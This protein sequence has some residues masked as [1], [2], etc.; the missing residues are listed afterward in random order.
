MI[1]IIPSLPINNYLRDINYISFIFDFNINLE[2]CGVQVNRSYIMN[3]F[4]NL[5]VYAGK[6]SVK[7]TRSFTDEEKSAIVQAVVVPSQ[8]GASVQF[9]MQGGGLTFIP[10]DQ[11]SQLAEGELVDLNVAQLVT[12]S[13]SGEADI[14]RV[15]I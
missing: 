15:S 1:V 5:Q 2:P 13:K 12:L 6:W 4:K 11:D 10:L 14:Y 7:E 9:T 3:I 8:Y